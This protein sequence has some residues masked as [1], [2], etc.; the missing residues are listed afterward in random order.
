MNMSRWP[1]SAPGSPG[2]T[3]EPE[4]ET[5]EGSDDPLHVP[6]LIA[7]S[8]YPWLLFH[9]FRRPSPS[10]FL[11]LVSTTIAPQS[12][13]PCW[14]ADGTTLVVAEALSSA[15]GFAARTMAPVFVMVG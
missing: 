1:S 8:Q 10:S 6:G 15:K 9:T 12:T 13:H 7:T 2:C 11:T 4:R 3:G 14:L 5:Q